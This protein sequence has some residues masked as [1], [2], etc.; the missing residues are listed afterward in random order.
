MATVYPYGSITASVLDEQFL[1]HDMVE[2]T[3][4]TLIDLLAHWARNLG[5]NVLD[6]IA[7][8]WPLVA[9]RWLCLDTAGTREERRSPGD[10]LFNAS[11]SLGSQGPHHGVMIHI[12]SS[13]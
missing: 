12:G 5:R 10:E 6:C 11:T 3:N 8:A 1:Q 9:G 4:T 7:P 13:M 2:D